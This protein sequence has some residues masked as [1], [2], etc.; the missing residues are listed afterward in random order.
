MIVDLLEYR[1]VPGHDAE[2]AGYLRHEAQRMPP[3]EGLISRFV[4]RRLSHEGRENLAATLWRDE[5][6]FAN[7]TDSAAVPKY[8]AAVSELLGDRASRRYRVVASTGIDRGGAKV[9][10]LYRTTL[11]TEMVGACERQAFERIGQLAI[12]DGLLAAVA[13]VEAGPV[14]EDQPTGAAR[15]VVL[16]TWTEWDA[17]LA[18][19]GGRLNRPLTDTELADLERPASADHFELVDADQRPA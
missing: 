13:A 10:R 2:L 19:T 5:R 1:V 15:V 14:D 8:L 4:G 9:L 18:A 3:A 12:M 7:G 17:L 6:A 16:T 11:A